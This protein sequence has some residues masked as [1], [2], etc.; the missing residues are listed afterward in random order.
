VTGIG[1]PRRPM[2]IKSDVVVTAPLPNTGVSPHS[3]LE[4]DIARKLVAGQLTLCRD[5]RAD[6]SRGF[7]KHRK[8]RVA[9]GSDGHAT[10]RCNGGPHDPIVLLEQQRVIIPDLL[11]QPC[12]TFDIG[13]Q[14]GHRSNR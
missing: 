10:G 9:F 13:K 3:H 14:E 2:D 6:R 1:D 12:G 5:R 11:Q 7:G 8:E 4:V